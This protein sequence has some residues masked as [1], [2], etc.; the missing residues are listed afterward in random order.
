MQAA[1]VSPYV[2]SLCAFKEFATWR[3]GLEEMQLLDRVIIAISGRGDIFPRRGRWPSSRSHCNCRSCIVATR[4]RA[5]LNFRIGRT[6]RPFESR[7]VRGDRWFAVKANEV[8]KGDLISRS[9]IGLRAH[10]F[11]NVTPYASLNF[12]WVSPESFPSF[13]LSVATIIAIEIFQRFRSVRMHF[14]E[15]L[16]SLARENNERRSP[17][18]GVFPNTLLLR[19]IITRERARGY[20][21]RKRGSTSLNKYLVS[22]RLFDRIVCTF[23]TLWSFLLFFF[24]SIIRAC[25]CNSF[26][27]FFYVFRIYLVYP[28]AKLKKSCR[29]VNN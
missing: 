26:F 2:E 28:L 16:T 17:R 25:V 15:C 24:F 8:L 22:E 14:A 18:A 10:T 27:F 6:L 4:R 1:C 7:S 23:Y 20:M 3:S 11:H 13:F 12:T 29:N 9:R 21:L 5:S 19:G